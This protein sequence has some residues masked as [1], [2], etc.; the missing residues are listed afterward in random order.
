MGLDEVQPGDFDLG[1]VLKMEVVL[2]I[3]NGGETAG[4][5]SQGDALRAPHVPK[6][7]ASFPRAVGPSGDSFMR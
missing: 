3:R 6:W 5:K 1:D 2:E 4:E 7:E